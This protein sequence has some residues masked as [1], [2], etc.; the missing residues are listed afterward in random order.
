MR[1]AKEDSG[2][3]LI[4]LA[5]VLP[6]LILFMGL[7]IDGGMAYI[8]KAKLSKA[9]DAACLTGMKNLWQGHAT[10][11]TLATPIF[12]AN[13]G[14]NPPT[15]TVTFPTDSY[16]NQQVSVTAT[17]SVPTFFAQRLISFW[18]VS[19]TATATRGKL[20]MSLVLDRSGSMAST[21][22]T[23]GGPSLKVAAP[24]FVNSWNNAVDKLAMVSFASNGTVDFPIAT[25]FQSPIDTAIGNLNFTGGTFGTGGTYV[26]G[27]GPPLTLA[28][29]QI[30]SVPI[31]AGDNIIRIA[32]YFTDGLMNTIQDTFTCY[33]NA[34]TKIT[35]LI[36]Y[37]GY[38]SGS[39]VDF[40][41]PTSATTDWGSYSTGV[42]YGTGKICQNPYGTNVTK[43][44]SQR[45]GLQTSINRTNV[46][47][48]AQYRALTTANAMRAE[49]PGTY[50]YVI[51]L[52]NQ[53]S[54]SVSTE[55]FLAT[56]A[57][58]S[59]GPSKYT[60]AIYNSSLPDGLFEPV[61]DCPSSACTTELNTAFQTIASK[62][63]L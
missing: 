50:I 9:V 30:T 14:T 31:A 25:N 6:V 63:L 43:F 5:I 8:T 29:H 39:T 53:I 37:G 22:A 52:G 41:D 44:L 28:D 18:S 62:I 15:P 49:T 46:T 21:G 1:G 47:A 36:N 33:T 19:D 58:D 20:V 54:G 11:T 55:A 40:F 56:L 4:V 61:P 51:G 45:T 59:T 3:I 42:L 2:Q 57:N 24:N 23:Q 17:A 16:G 60:G 34:T 38:D 12:N 13:Y 32:I 27:D 7:T 10:A 26:A 35:P 48:E